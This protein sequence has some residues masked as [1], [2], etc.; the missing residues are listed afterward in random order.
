MIEA[1]S[2]GSARYSYPFCIM[3]NREGQRF[4]DDG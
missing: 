3:V 2:S 1:A 4:V